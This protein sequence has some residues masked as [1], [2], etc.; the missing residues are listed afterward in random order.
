MGGESRAPFGMVLGVDLGAVSVRAAIAG[1]NHCSVLPL[2]QSGA[3]TPSAIGF[4]DGRVLLGDRAHARAATDPDRVALDPIGR[5]LAGPLRSRDQTFSAETV[6]GW[7]LDAIL[8][9]ARSERDDPVSAL[10]VCVPTSA[11]DDVAC[12]FE[13]AAA[14]RGI[15]KTT[16][17]AVTTAAALGTVAV[18]R[19]SLGTLAVVDIGATHADVAI[20]QLGRGFLRIRSRAHRTD[21]HAFALDRRISEAFVQDVAS[22]DVLTGLHPSVLGLI[23]QH[24]ARVRCD[25]SQATEARLSVPFLAPILG[26]A[27]LTDWVIDRERL[28]HFAAD[29]A[30]LV[31]KTCRAAMDAA[32]VTPAGID[33]VACVGGLGRMPLLRRE[34]TDAFGKAPAGQVNPDTAAS[35]GAA[36]LGASSIG[37]LAFRVDERQI[38]IA[39]WP[40]EDSADSPSDDGRAAVVPDAP[41]PEPEPEEKPALVHRKPSH[42]HLEMAAK[43]AANPPVVADPPREQPEPEEPSRPSIGAMLRSPEPAARSEESRPSH[44]PSVDIPRSGPFRNAL[45][46]ERMLGLPFAR[47]MTPDDVSPPALPILLMHYGRCKDLMAVLTVRRGDVSWSIP[48]VGAQLAPP[49][50]SDKE[51]FMSAFTWPD[52]EYSIATGE[53]PGDAGRYKTESLAKVAIEGVRLALQQLPDKAIVDCLGTRMDEAPMVSKRGMAMVDALGFWSGEKRYLRYRCDGSIPT[54]DAIIAGGISTSSALHALFVL[55]L[56]GQVTWAPLKREAAP[57]LSDEVREKA[58]TLQR[59]NA[60]D[61]LGVHWSSPEHE[62]QAAYDRLMASYGP[63]SEAAKAAPDAAASIVAKLGEALPILLDRTK[64]LALL[65]QTRPDLDYQAI[66]DL[67]QNQ[68]TTLQLR[69]AGGDADHALR[70]QRDVAPL[71][72]LS[73]YDR[74]VFASDPKSTPKDED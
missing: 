18:T 29:L 62:A 13:A 54:R 49:L 71:S 38:R 32:E 33:M 8:E 22:K 64:R 56:L 40:D 14:E 12:W 10:A 2:G 35:L 6:V 72:K 73:G 31:R 42:A 3:A 60:F 50:M 4:I 24:S 27:T 5:L 46:P 23:D 41:D 52:G 16:S 53:V 74:R 26:C 61:V 55:H 19:S 68:A 20:V 57:S 28:E 65:K 1:P 17:H 21:S 25:L 36:M 43:L 69:G 58:K 47:P 63:S 44:A 59:A 34:V 48:I 7:W 30:T 70:V 67:M 11:P 45:T 15:L 66:A 51:R 39:Q 9:K 37:L